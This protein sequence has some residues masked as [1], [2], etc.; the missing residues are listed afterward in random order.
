LDNN[1]H[2]G[3]PKAVIASAAIILLVCVLGPSFG[4]GSN[5]QKAKAIEQEQ[6]PQPQQQQQAS[7]TIK[8][9]GTSEVPGGICSNFHNSDFLTIGF[10]A[11]FLLSPDG[12]TGKVTSGSGILKTT[13]SNVFGY[14]SITGGTV[15]MGVQPELY[16]LSGTTSFRSSPSSCNLPSTAKFS[17]AKPDGSQLKCGE[18]TDLITFNSIPLTGS[19]TGNVNCTTATS[20]PAVGATQTHPQSNIKTHTMPP[21]NVKIISATDGQGR[22]ISNGAVNILSKSITFQ[23]SRPTD[24]VGIASLECNIDGSTTACPSPSSGGSVVRYNN[25]NPGSHTFTFTAKD[26]EGNTSSAIFTWTISANAGG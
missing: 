17:I 12:K 19:V 1:P 5:M 15:N 4:G 18:N 13:Y 7:G 14:L 8:G 10:H 22:R 24:N 2:V 26:S 16:L 6:Q 3:K 23:L 20:L 21:E 11:S 25:L 9:D